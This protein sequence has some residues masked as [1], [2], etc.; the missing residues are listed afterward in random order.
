MDDERAPR[1]WE[2]ARRVVSEARRSGLVVPGFRSPP[3]VPGA[4]RTVRRH[5]GGALV[6][7][8]WR[9]RSAAA[10]VADM[11][12]G[13]VL[14]NGLAGAEAAACRRRLWA[15]LASADCPAP[16]TIEPSPVPPALTLVVAPPPTGEPAPGSGN[17]PVA[18]GADRW[19][20]AAL[21][22]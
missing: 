15:G 20:P 5:P 3:R 7:V 4:V 21:T 18:G 6:A 9:G 2:L 8:A 17:A 22:G 1:F 13:L 14:V 10:V 16:E 11:V 19:S 12:D